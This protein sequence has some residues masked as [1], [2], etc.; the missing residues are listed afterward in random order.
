MENYERRYGAPE[1]PLAKE[2]SENYNSRLTQ[3]FYTQLGMDGFRKNSGSEEDYTSS[4]YTEELS[5][6][7]NFSSQVSTTRTDG[8]FE[9]G[10]MFDVDHESPLEEIGSIFD[11][12]EKRY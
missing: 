12:G 10:S 3:E 2:G 4:E 8:G 1:V 6:Y 11:G 5:D 7:G 9:S